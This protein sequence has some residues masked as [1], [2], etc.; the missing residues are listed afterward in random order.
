GFC[1]YWDVLR[2]AVKMDSS[3]GAGELLTQ[4]GDVCVLRLLEALLQTL[5]HLLLQTYVVVAVEP[6]GIVPGKWGVPREGVS[7][8]GGVMCL[9]G[10]GLICGRAQ[11]RL[12]KAWE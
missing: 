10:G 5:P 11:D 7:S 8:G 2:L 3:A 9:D 6:A 1:R 12:W 4:R